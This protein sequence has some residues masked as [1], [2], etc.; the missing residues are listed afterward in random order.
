MEEDEEWTRHLWAGSSSVMA[1]LEL[2]TDMLDEKVETEKLGFPLLVYTSDREYEAFAVWDTFSSL[3][4]ITMKELERVDQVRHLIRYPHSKRIVLAD[5]RESELVIGHVTLVIILAGGS[6]AHLKFHVLLEC[7]VPMIVGL[8]GGG[9][10]GFS[11]AG[12]PHQLPPKREDRLAPGQRLPPSELEEESDSSVEGGPDAETQKY[13]FDCLRGVIDA[14]E[15]LP[16]DTALKHPDAEVVLDTGQ[17]PPMYTRPYPIPHSMKERVLARIKEWEE[18]GFIEPSTSKWNHPLV[19]A[20]KKSGGKVDESDVRLCVAA[21][22]LNSALPKPEYNL[23]TISDIFAQLEGAKFVSSL[24]GK[25]AYHLLTLSK[26]SREKTAFTAPDMRRWQWVRAFFGISIIASHFQWLIESVL[27]EFREHVLIYIDDIVIYS[28]N[29]N[30]DEHLA[31]VSRVISKLTEVGFKLSLPKC[32]FAYR[33]LRVL[34]FVLDGKVRTVDPRKVEQLRQIP[35]PTTGKA[36][37][38]WLGLTCFL[39]EFVPLYAR[40]CEPLERLRGKRSLKKLWGKLEQRAFETLRD[41]ISSQTKLWM[42]DWDLEFLLDTDASQ[43][44]IGWILYQIVKNALGKEEI[45]YIAFGSKALSI[46]QVNY[47]AHKR[48]LLALITAIRSNRH[49]LVGRHFRVFTDHRA[50]VALNNPKHKLDYMSAS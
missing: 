40:V 44:G 25:G 21:K 46:S 31:L 24:D 19:A 27:A 43:Y 37:E 18:L 23:P 50:L 34:G 5:G 16:A 15:R 47:G 28:K 14:N 4:V 7:V 9:E 35:A 36:L 41:A 13:I 6:H 1:P 42:A 22:T 10:L 39:R 33:R 17:S 20:Q 11:V 30:L 32:R 12:L 3:N 38:A 8:R 48:E 2:S 26:S 49:Y 29:D 45:R